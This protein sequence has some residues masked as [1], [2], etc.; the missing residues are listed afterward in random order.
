MNSIL[1]NELLDEKEV[2]LARTLL[3]VFE[4]QKNNKRVTISYT[5]L[6]EKLQKD[7]SIIIYKQDL[8]EPLGKIARICKELELPI[9]TSIV[10]LNNSREPSTGYP[11]ILQNLGFIEDAYADDEITKEKIKAEKIKGQSHKDWE[12]LKKYL[13]D[14]YGKT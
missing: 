3:N 4:E 13:D 7:Y 6:S 9:I 2:A 1:E 8:G 11:I 5:E 14:Y 12:K 10:V